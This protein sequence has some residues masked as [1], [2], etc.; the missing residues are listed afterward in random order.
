M[1]EEQRWAWIGKQRERKIPSERHP[2]FLPCSQRRVNEAH[3]SCASS[4]YLAARDVLQ[5]EG[6]HGAAPGSVGCLSLTSHLQSWCPVHS[7]HSAPPGGIVCS[8]GDIG[9][10][11]C[12]ALLPA[13]EWVPSE[14]S[15]VRAVLLLPYSCP[16]VAQVMLGV[17][18]STG[19]WW[20]V[21]SRYIT[22]GLACVW[23]K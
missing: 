20:S 1:G 8:H 3:R 5:Y 19:F 17:T 7:P 23:G 9:L 4:V 22:T 13:D 12:E 15:Q 14:Q 18:A 6:R 11:H 21:G 2:C 16:R 10:Q